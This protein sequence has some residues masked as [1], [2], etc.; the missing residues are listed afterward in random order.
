MQHQ[1]TAPSKAHLGGSQVVGYLNSLTGPSSEARPAT[2]P[3]LPGTIPEL[4]G[5]TSELPGTTPELPGTTPE[6]PDMTFELPGPESLLP[7]VLSADVSG[8]ESVR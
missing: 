8:R 3:E 6:L 1:P 5:T 2:T 4:P 7:N